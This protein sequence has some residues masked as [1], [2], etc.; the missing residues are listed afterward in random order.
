LKELDVGIE[1][2]PD[3]CADEFE[4]FGWLRPLLLKGLIG[5]PE[6]ACGT[7]DFASVIHEWSGVWKWGRQ[8][9]LD[10]ETEIKYL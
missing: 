3:N 6:C 7:M 10:P 4:A 1:D 5:Q 8:T 9:W 2:A